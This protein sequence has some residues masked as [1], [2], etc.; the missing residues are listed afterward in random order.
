MLYAVVALL[1]SSRAVACVAIM[2]VSTA[3]S[4]VFDPERRDGVVRCHSA[5]DCPEPEDNRWAQEC[6]LSEDIDLEG[7]DADHVCVAVFNPLS[8]FPFHY[9]PDSRFRLLYSA[10]TAHNG[11]RYK[12]VCHL[13]PGVQ[14]CP[15]SSDFG[16]VGG[17]QV[18]DLTGYCDDDDPSTPRAEEPRERLAGQDVQDQF[19]RSFFC[20]KSF[21]CDNRGEATCVPC[22]PEGSLGNGGCGDL[23]FE[24]KPSPVYE[25]IEELEDNCLAPDSSEDEVNLGPLYEPSAEEPN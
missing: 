6:V 14:G 11:V 19:C 23:Y 7:H 16:C 8:C 21:V 9:A 24:G 4:F 3:C 10:A 2:V 18:D 15:P 12:S 17:L 22:N 20:D 13:T 1:A 5:A 25:D